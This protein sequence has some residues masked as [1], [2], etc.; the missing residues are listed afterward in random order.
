MRRSKI[1][2]KET[3]DWEQPRLKR[4]LILND[5]SVNHEGRGEIS[6]A[7]RFLKHT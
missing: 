1:C 4:W 7:G 5:C 6:K 2:R 3:V